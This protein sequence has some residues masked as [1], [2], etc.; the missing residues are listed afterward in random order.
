M[1]YEDEE[2]K[3]DMEESAKEVDEFINGDTEAMAKKMIDDGMD[4]SFVLATMRLAFAMAAI[5]DENDF[6]GTILSTIALEMFNNKDNPTEA[7]KNVR[8]TAAL[9]VNQ[10]AKY[11]ECASA[12]RQV[13]HV[14]K[15]FADGFEDKLTD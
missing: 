3:R 9:M 1:S 11:E 4:P 12:F 7:V 13:A 14:I 6:Q 10:A 2:F 5:Q 15:Q 8:T